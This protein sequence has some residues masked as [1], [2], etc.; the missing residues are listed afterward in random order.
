MTSYFQEK[1]CFCPFSGV[2]CN[3]NCMLW[4]YDDEFG[5]N[6]KLHYGHCLFRD[7]LELE[8]RRLNAKGLV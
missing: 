4:D 6:K 2:K 3:P 7:K 5:N 8:I 1:D